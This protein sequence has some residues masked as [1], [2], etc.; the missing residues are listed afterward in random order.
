MA[1]KRKIKHLR[2][3]IDAMLFF[4]CV[5]CYLDRSTLTVVAD[6]MLTDLGI[7]EIEYGYVV[8]TFFFTYAVFYTLSGFFMDKVGTRRGFSI[9]IFVWSVA[10][11]MHAAVRNVWHLAIARF[12]LGV[13]EGGNYPGATKVTAEWFPPKE[14]SIAVGYFNMGS[15]IGA[16]IAPPIVGFVTHYWGWQEAFVVTGLSGF[17]WFAL[18]LIIGYRPEEH[19]RVHRSEFL[20]IKEKAD[21]ITYPDEDALLLNEKRNFTPQQLAVLES[22]L[23]RRKKSLGFS[24]FLLIAFGYL[25]LHRF[26]LKNWFM[27][28]AYLVNTALYLSG[29]IWNSVALLWIAGVLYTAAILFDLFSQYNRISLFNQ[30]IE[31][32]TIDKIT[33]KKV[34]WVEPSDFAEQ[35]QSKEEGE[36]PKVPAYHLFRY[37]ETWG[38]FFARFWGDQVWY[39]YYSWIGLILQRVYGYSII[40]LAAVLWIP[41]ALADVGS[42]VGGWS[43]RFLIGRGWDPLRAR[44][45][46]VF[47]YS[48]LMP[49]TIIGAFTGGHSWIFICTASLAVFSH[50]AWVANIHTISMDCFPSKYVGTVAGWG[51]TGGSISGGISNAIIGNLVVLTGGYTLVITVFGFF[52]LIAT[53]GI[54]FFNRRYHDVDKELADKLVKPGEAPARGRRGRPRKTAKAKSQWWSKF[55]SHLKGEDL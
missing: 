47:F 32:E 20:Y 48:A 1:R 3:Y 13:G 18:W 29:H 15:M 19:K 6:R 36:G 21:K 54:Y 50:T 27:G 39:F 2:W 55:K 25:G 10:S 52:H 17:I 53:A 30:E 8:S 45:A 7:T 23:S 33:G 43:S 37:T 28:A 38:L 35:K 14:R 49:I 24:Y 16:T 5:I 44:K 34:E 40:D 22:E 46:M 31:E 41:F 11:I 12:F 4:A 42:I 9:I 51:G 26:Y